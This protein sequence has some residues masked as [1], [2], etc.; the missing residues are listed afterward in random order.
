MRDDEATQRVLRTPE[1][2]LLT[3]DRVA[4]ALSSACMGD[5]SF[6]NVLVV[7]AA[8]NAIFRVRSTAYTTSAGVVDQIRARAA[9]NAIVTASGPADPHSTDLMWR[10]MFVV[11]GVGQ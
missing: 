6:G 11:F 7:S 8:L 4:A 9:W 10:L 3:Y 5:K 2:G 1:C